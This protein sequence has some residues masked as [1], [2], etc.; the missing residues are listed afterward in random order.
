M[1]ELLYLIGGWVGGWETYCAG[2]AAV[3]GKV[4][5]PMLRDVMDR[6][7][8]VIDFGVGVVVGQAV[9]GK[10]LFRKVGG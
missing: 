1:N 8:D 4:L 9:L 10:E 2:I 3:V 5:V 6:T 7:D